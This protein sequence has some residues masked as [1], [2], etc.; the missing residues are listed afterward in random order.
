MDLES[1]SKNKNVT[2]LVIL[3]KKD[4]SGW[5]ISKK[6]IE[7]ERESMRETCMLGRSP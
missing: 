4:I 5:L 1:V 6:N 3:N 7:R 2:I